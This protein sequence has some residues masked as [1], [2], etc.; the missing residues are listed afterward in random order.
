MKK[1]NYGKMRMN[2]MEIGRE[3]RKVRNE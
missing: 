2:V 3:D 1:W